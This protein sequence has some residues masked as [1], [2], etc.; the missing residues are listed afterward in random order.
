V[1]E[2]VHLEHI[3]HNSSTAPYLTWERS[4]RTQRHPRATPIAFQLQTAKFSSCQSTRPARLFLT[5]RYQGD[6]G[7]GR[8]TKQ[9][10]RRLFIYATSD[11][12]KGTFEDRVW[13]FAV[14]YRRS[15]G[16][17]RQRYAQLFQTGNFLDREWRSFALL[18]AFRSFTG[19][20]FLLQQLGGR[21]GSLSPSWRTASSLLSMRYT[22]LRHPVPLSTGK[23]GDTRSATDRLL[24]ASFDFAP[25]SLTFSQQAQEWATPTFCVGRSGVRF[26]RWRV[27]FPVL[28]CRRKCGPAARRRDGRRSSP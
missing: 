23:T 12:L 21:L 18:L 5:H 13:Q 1:E 22:M 6:M 20:F 19:F 25:S 2:V 26:V 7:G 14:D 4:T 9:E 17:C 27:A 24:N 11:E 10:D 8:W 15:I 28:H 3:T 16:A